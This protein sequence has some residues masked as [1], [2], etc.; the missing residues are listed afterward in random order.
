MT[1]KFKPCMDERIT[2]LVN[3]EKP[4]GEPLVKGRD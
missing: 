4:A 1:G 2:G 3:L